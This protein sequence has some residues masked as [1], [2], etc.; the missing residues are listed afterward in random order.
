MWEFFGHILSFYFPKM[1]VFPHMC[2]SL[3]VMPTGEGLK[4]ELICEFVSSLA[5]LRRRISRSESLRHRKTAHPPPPYSHPAMQLLKSTCFGKSSLPRLNPW[6]V[7]LLGGVSTRVECSRP[8]VISSSLQ[9]AFKGVR[10]L[11]FV[12]WYLS[13]SDFLRSCDTNSETFSPIMQN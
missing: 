5:N 13:D 11:L 10:K 8:V 6:A 7:G 1:L 2:I 4:P 9:R 3:V 12:S